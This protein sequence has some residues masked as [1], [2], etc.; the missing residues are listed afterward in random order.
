MASDYGLHFGFRRSDESYRVAEGRFRTPATGNALLIG[1]CVEID[2]ANP[3][4]VRVAAANAA[5][6]TGV[7][8]VLLQEEF[9]VSIFSVGEV[10]SFMRGV[11]KRNRL[12]VI[13]NGAGTKVWFKNVDATNRADGRA[14][15]AVSIVDFTGG[16]AVGDQLGWNGT[17]WAKAATPAAA[18][19]EVTEVDSAKGYLEAVFLK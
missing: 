19:M 7:C 8:G 11:A 10:D 6:R 17:K 4:F 1:T 15:N 13:T 12:S 3:G 5:A 2:P 9:D 18:H 16:I 14:T